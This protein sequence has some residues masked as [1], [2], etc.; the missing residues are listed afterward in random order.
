MIPTPDEIIKYAQKSLKEGKNA[1]S[2]LTAIGMGYFEKG[3]LDK[4]VYYYRKALEQNPDFAP[5]FAGLGIVFGKKGR[6]TESIFNLKEAIR[7]APGCAI[8][9]NWLADAFFDQGRFED[10]IREYGKATQQNALD[11]NAHN[12]MA[13]A[14]RITGNLQKAM[15][16]YNETLR[17]DP[18]DT[19]ALL[20]RA[21]VLIQL[22]RREEARKNL[23]TLLREHPDSDDTKTAKVVL[24]TMYVQAGDFI[25]ARD[26][27]N[28]SARDYPFNPS[29]QFQLG[30]CYLVLEDPEQAIKHLNQSKDLDP[31][32]PRVKRLLQQLG[33]N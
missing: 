32:N 17:L 22:N 10:A 12:D 26:F 31:N 28:Q 7:F 29:I 33:K 9:Y 4:S 6:V 24:G 20:E 21:Q 3:L 2:A 16:H 5:A 30:L 8:L 1:P 14:Y 18:G 19:N 25:S 13:D 15:D 27:F 23:M 11:S